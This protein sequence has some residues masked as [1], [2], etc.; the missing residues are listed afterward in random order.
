MSMS[1]NLLS[2][3][4]RVGRK[5]MSMSEQ[6]L[7]GARKLILNML[8]VIL[9]NTQKIRETLTK[10]VIVPPKLS[11]S[12]VKVCNLVFLPSDVFFWGTPK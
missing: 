9:V 8:S 4:F 1:I 7:I 2:V 11:L 10:P 3:W 6:K 12:H 5:N